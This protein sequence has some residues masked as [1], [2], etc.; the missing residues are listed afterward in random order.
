MGLCMEFRANRF[1]VIFNLVACE[2]HKGRRGRNHFV[3]LT[4]RKILQGL[5]KV[6]FLEIYI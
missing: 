4:E 6:F 3:N 1:T 2:C 5:K